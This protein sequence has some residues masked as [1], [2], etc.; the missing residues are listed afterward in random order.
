MKRIKDFGLVLVGACAGAAI[1]MAA[2]PVRA[3]FGQKQPPRLTVA[4][5]PYESR[6]SF[7]NPV[8]PQPY[9]GGWKFIL[10]SKSAGC[11]LLIE[12]G[13]NSP[14]LAPAP[15]AACQQ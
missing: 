9:Y 3:Q 11:W 10:D 14:A 15:P 8:P 5:Q 6:D 2:T 7:G 1:A 12:N 4:G 13:N